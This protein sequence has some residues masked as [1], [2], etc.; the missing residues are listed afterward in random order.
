MKIKFKVI[1]F[2]III[3]LFSPI[4]LQ[5]V[6]AAEEQ[7]WQQVP[8][9]NYAEVLELIAFELIALRAKANYEKISSWQGRVNIF[10][11]NHYYGPNAAKMVGADK[12]IFGRHS[13][14]IFKEIVTVHSILDN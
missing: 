2:C 10:K 8:K 6:T 1:S 12:D 9:A 11:T 5:E 4:I 3:L 7:Q 13:K 14:Y